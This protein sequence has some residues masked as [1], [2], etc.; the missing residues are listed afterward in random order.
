MRVSGR[1]KDLRHFHCIKIN[2]EDSLLHFHK[3]KPVGLSKL[4]VP[5][6]MAPPGESAI[7]PGLH[8]EKEEACGGLV[9]LTK[10][11][12]VSFELRVFSFKGNVVSLELNVVSFKLNIVSFQNSW[13]AAFGHRSSIGIIFISKIVRS[14]Y[15]FSIAS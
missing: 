1:K 5:L 6:T 3:V 12:I 9:F 10:R 15:R 14:F 13:L 11:N 2:V 8:M 4:L 7:V